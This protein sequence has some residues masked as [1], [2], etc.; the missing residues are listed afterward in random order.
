MNAKPTPPGQPPKPAPPGHQA[1][2]TAPVT[3]ATN[4]PLPH[5]P[6]QNNKAPVTRVV[7]ELRSGARFATTWEPYDPEAPIITATDVLE[8]ALTARIASTKRPVKTEDLASV[9]H[10][11]ALTPTRTQYRPVTL[12]TT[13]T[14]TTPAG[15]H[16]LRGAE[17]TVRALPGMDLARVDRIIDSP[18]ATWLGWNEATIYADTEFQVVLGA[19]RD[20]EDYVLHVSPLSSADDTA[21]GKGAAPARRRVPGQKA[22]ARRPTPTSVAEMLERVREYG[23]EVDD[24]RR[25]YSISHPGTPGIGL[26]VPRTPSDHRWAE[27]TVSQIRR[28]FGIDIRQPR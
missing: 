4:P 25:H 22:D 19:P 23:F 14:T 10:E 16:L 7:L 8:G 12:G 28:V 9:S 18:A 15:R 3:A 27:N 6:T 17:R 11:V 20:G 2:G 26:P 1:P 5:P 24:T 21:G 13:R